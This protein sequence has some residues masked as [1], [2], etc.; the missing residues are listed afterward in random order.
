MTLRLLH[1]IAMPPGPEFS[2]PFGKMEAAARTKLEKLARQKL[3]N[4][5]NYEVDIMMGDLSAVLKNV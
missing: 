3:R 2:L 4:W 1:V 5:A